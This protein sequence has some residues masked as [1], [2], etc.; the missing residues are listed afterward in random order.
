[1]LFIS[2]SQ[3]DE[4]NLNFKLNIRIVIRNCNSNDK[5]Y[6]GTFKAVLFKGECEF[7]QKS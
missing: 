6:K 1:M 3:G 5:Y 2:I 7:N 4:S